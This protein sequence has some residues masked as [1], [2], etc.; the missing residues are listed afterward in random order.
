MKVDPTKAKTYRQFKDADAKKKQ[1][2]QAIH[3]AILAATFPDDYTPTNVALE[4]ESSD[5]HA[6]Y[7]HYDDHGDIR[8]TVILRHA[9]ALEEDVANKRRELNE[10]TAA[11]NRAHGNK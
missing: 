11:L 10:L 4:A 3:N 5:P 6:P 2:R 9:T 8:V 1:R 7:G